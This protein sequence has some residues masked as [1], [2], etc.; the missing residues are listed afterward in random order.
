MKT[1][2]LKPIYD[3]RW[4]LEYNDGSRPRW[5][6]WTRSDTEPKNMASFQKTNHLARAFIEVRDKR[7]F[8]TSIPVHCAGID[9]VMFKWQRAAK[10]ATN[11][12]QQSVINQKPNSQ[13]V[14]LTLV[15]RELEATVRVDNI[16]PMIKKRTKEDM[17][18]HY[19][20]FG[21]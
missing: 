14:G 13:I 9:F 21:K 15:S 4:R 5:G 17:N 7:N 10:I 8:K 16:T 3:V 11:I 19:E 12:N 20:G 18:F 2:L 6:Q 1:P